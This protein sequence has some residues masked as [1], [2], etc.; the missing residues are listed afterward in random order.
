MPTVVLEAMA[1]ARPILV[2]DVGATAELVDASNGYLLPPG[3]VDAL[4]AAV[5]GLLERGHAERSSMGQ[6]S[7]ERVRSSFT[8]PVVTE[9]FVAL[10][11]TLVKR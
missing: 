2:S 1:R 3:D 7:L 10:F 8:W 9:G 6:R 4:Y 11:N 5:L